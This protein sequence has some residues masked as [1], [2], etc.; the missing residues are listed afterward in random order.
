MCF[1]MNEVA[2]MNYALLVRKR[3]VIP[4]RFMLKVNFNINN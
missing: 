2:R 4:L 1:V 3:E